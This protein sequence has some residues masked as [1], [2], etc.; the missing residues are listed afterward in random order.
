[1]MCLMAATVEEMDMEVTEMTLMKSYRGSWRPNNEPEFE[2]DGILVSVKPAKRTTM[3][4]F[5]DIKARGMVS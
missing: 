1:M 3:S 4:T 5:R 2:D